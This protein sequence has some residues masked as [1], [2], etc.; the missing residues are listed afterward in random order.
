MVAECFLGLRIPPQFVEGALGSR[1]QMP[2]GTV[3]MELPR[4]ARLELWPSVVEPTLLYWAA[5]VPVTMDQPLPVK[6]TNPEEVAEALRSSA[7]PDLDPKLP[8]HHATVE[9]YDACIEALHKERLPNAP[10]L[11]FPTVWKAA[12]AWLLRNC[13]AKAFHK[14][15]RVRFYS[16]QHDGK[17]RKRGEH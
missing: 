13:N 17:R 10:P 9:E 8:P 2:V 16:S 12:P 15:M 6:V 11:N 5:P 7:Q 1:L 4:K 14:I 3:L